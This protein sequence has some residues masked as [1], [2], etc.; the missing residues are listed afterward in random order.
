[1]AEMCREDFIAM[2]IAELT[3]QKSN[4]EDSFNNI[5]TRGPKDIFQSMCFDF[6]LVT[7][8]EMLALAGE[9]VSFASAKSTKVAFDT[10]WL[11]DKFT[12]NLMYLSSKAAD[13]KDD[14]LA[15][16]SLC[17]AVYLRLPLRLLSM[18]RSELSDFFYGISS[19]SEFHQSSI[20]N[21][22]TSGVDL[23]SW[24]CICQKFCSFVRQGTASLLC[25]VQLSALLGDKNCSGGHLADLS[26]TVRK[27]QDDSTVK[28][29]SVN[30]KDPNIITLEECFIINRELTLK[31]ELDE[32]KTLSLI[33]SES[34]TDVKIDSN[35]LSGPSECT[36]INGIAKD[37][38]VH[39]SFLSRDILVQHPELLSN[40]SV[41]SKTLGVLIPLGTNMMTSSSSFPTAKECMLALTLAGIAAGITSSTVSSR[42]IS[43]SVPK[44]EEVGM[45]DVIESAYVRN[46]LRDQKCSEAR[47]GVRQYLN[48]STP[49]ILTV[50]VGICERMR[51]TPES[52]N[53]D[54][55]VL[56]YDIIPLYT[57]ITNTLPH[58]HEHLMTSRAVSV[59]VQMW[60]RMTNHAL[61]NFS[62][63]DGISDP[64]SIG[65][66]TGSKST[67]NSMLITASRFVNANLYI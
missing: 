2:M 55:A 22:A 7:S 44:E 40:P 34:D 51:N 10:F 6:P 33:N 63:I 61:D 16:S 29:K 58:Q 45:S 31:E 15:I 46:K 36:V 3:L 28:G 19:Q 8:E 5:Q 37:V 53:N 23:L 62:E 52:V 50:I 64:R 65:Q 11:N 47:A 1:M 67:S 35:D 48:S 42:T 54:G 27:M 26:E 56:L 49:S 30:I 17:A 25:N 13:N 66:V 20:S 12:E 38:W 9:V 32:D 24:V 39:L 18:T 4:N 60:I 57:D 43:S 59:L 41:L 21:S 14:E